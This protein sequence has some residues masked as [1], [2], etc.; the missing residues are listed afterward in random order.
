MMSLLVS[1]SYLPL[2]RQMVIQHASSLKLLTRIQDVILQH[3]NN[4]HIYLRTYSTGSKLI[5]Q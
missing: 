4:I 1:F 2:Q 5:M 3:F